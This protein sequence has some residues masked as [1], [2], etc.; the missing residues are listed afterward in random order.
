MKKI[1]SLWIYMAAENTWMKFECSAGLLTGKYGNKNASN[2]VLHGHSKI[3][4]AINI[5][6]LYLEEIGTGCHMVLVDGFL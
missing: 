5:I 1:M 4:C 2:L 3:N 6:I